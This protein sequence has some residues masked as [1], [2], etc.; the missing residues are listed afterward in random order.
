MDGEAEAGLQ[1]ATD[2]QNGCA[3]NSIA[4]HKEE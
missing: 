4:I 2:R 3:M 1:E